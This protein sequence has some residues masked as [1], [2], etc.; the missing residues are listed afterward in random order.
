MFHNSINNITCVIYLQKPDKPKPPRPS[1]PPS[2]P[3]PPK[4]L[5]SGAPRPAPSGG[6]GGAPAPGNH[7]TVGTSRGSR[8]PHVFF[9]INTNETSICF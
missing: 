6:S 1:A 8:P 7:P 3:P 5:P 9:V 2:R 4:K